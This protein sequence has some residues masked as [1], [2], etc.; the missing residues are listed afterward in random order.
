LI[1]A[2]ENVLMA[3]AAEV[4]LPVAGPARPLP[5]AAATEAHD[6]PMQ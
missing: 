6:T 4:L 3:V 1:D 5:L 2:Y